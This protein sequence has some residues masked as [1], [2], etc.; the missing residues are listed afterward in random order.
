[1]YVPSTTPWLSSVFGILGGGAY[2]R[3]SPFGL[4]GKMIVDNQKRHWICSSM[5][6]GR[7]PI[8]AGVSHCPDWKEMA[9]RARR[10]DASVERRTLRASVL[11]DPVPVFDLSGFFEVGRW[12]DVVTLY[13]WAAPAVR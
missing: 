10:S 7:A 5:T 13:V 1:M 11:A 6:P 8:P 3:T 2:T 12:A 9:V 4:A